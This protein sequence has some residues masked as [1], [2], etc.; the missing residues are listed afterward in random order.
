MMCVKK[1]RAKRCASSTPTQE[2]KKQLTDSEGSPARL[3]HESHVKVS[4]SQK[5]QQTLIGLKRPMRFLVN[6][7]SRGRYN[8]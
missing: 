7:I 3:N 5:V 2:L 6:I 1:I 8:A 4:A